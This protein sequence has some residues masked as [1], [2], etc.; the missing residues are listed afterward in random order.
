MRRRTLRYAVGLAEAAEAMVTRAGHTAPPRADLIA[1]LIPPCRRA[2]QAQRVLRW[3]ASQHEAAQAEADAA[4]EAMS[5]SVEAVVAAW[6]ARSPPVQRSLVD[7]DPA[8]FTVV[9]AAPPRDRAALPA[10]EVS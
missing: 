4:A 10:R 6:L 2:V 9:L 3:A 7:F 8:R 1:A 5:D